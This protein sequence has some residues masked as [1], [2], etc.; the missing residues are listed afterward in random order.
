MVGFLPFAKCTDYTHEMKN[1]TGMSHK[2]TIIRTY[3]YAHNSKPLKKI[4][5]S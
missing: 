4:S 3:K 1:Q 2:N 5:K